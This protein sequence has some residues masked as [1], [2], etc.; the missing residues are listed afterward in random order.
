MHLHLL[1]KLAEA[2]ALKRKSARAACSLRG[3]Y[4]LMVVRSF[5]RR[6]G[7]PERL[8]FAVAGFKP[9]GPEGWSAKRQTVTPTSNLAD[10]LL[11]RPPRRGPVDR[12]LVPRGPAGGGA[13]AIPDEHHKI[14]ERQ[15]NAPSLEEDDWGSTPKK[16]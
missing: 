15:R 7:R 13:R 12:D 10:V 2:A 14:L 3:A 16:K 9:S 1:E 4:H 11:R 5:G 8:G 6:S